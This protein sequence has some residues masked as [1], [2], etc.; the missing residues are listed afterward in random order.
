MSWSVT[1]RTATAEDTRELAASLAPLARSG[2]VVLLA[3]GL[4]AGKTTFAQGFARGLGV[5]GPVTSPTFTLVRQYAGTALQ[6]LHA[7]VYRLDTLAEVADLALSELVEDGAVLLVEWGDAAAPALG[8]ETLTV[9]LEPGAG[10]DERTAV[11]T[12]RGARWGDLRPAVVAALKP[13]GA[14]R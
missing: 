4:G 1:V 5:V 3:G 9:A 6:L 2:D 10:A 11:V 14:E 7:D 12:G 8:D 13:W